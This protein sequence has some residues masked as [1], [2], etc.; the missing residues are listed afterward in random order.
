MKSGKIPYNYY[1]RDYARELRNNP[2]KAEKI[3][4]AHIKKDQLGVRF[5]R[6]VPIDKFIVDFYCYSLRFAIEVDGEIHKYQV[7]YDFERQTKLESEYGITF[8]RFTNEETI[9]NLFEAVKTIEAVID[10]LRNK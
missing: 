5:N 9:Q 3:L 6:Q 2:T 8:L 10:E 1:L 4:W 7:Q